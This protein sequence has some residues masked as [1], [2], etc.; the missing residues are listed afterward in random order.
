ML[1]S[2]PVPSPNDWVDECE[3]LDLDLRRKPVN[4]EKCGQGKR[5]RLSR[6]RRFCTTEGQTKRGQ[7]HIHI[8]VV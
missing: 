3:L 8:Q 4:N 5:L 1:L 6:G 2:R 7:C